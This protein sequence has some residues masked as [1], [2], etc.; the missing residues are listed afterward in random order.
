MNKI[1]P[2]VKPED[3][4]FCKDMSAWDNSILA[5]ELK[6]GYRKEPWTCA[7]STRAKSTVQPVLGLLGQKDAPRNMAEAMDSEC[8]LTDIVDRFGGKKYNEGFKAWDTA[9]FDKFP[10]LQKT[11]SQMITKARFLANAGF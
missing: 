4:Q 8:I 9:N 5:K 6:S 10:N 2:S 1:S 3:K 7:A 11:T